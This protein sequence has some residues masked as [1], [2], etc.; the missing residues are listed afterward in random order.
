MT[1]FVHVRNGSVQVGHQYGIFTYKDTL[2]PKCLV[3]EPCLSGV[4][5]IVGTGVTISPHES[6]YFATVDRMLAVEKRPRR[7]RGA[8]KLS[9]LFEILMIASR[10]ALFALKAWENRVRSADR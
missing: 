10:F 3:N 6:M 1:F 8:P 9:A 7:R 4:L 5:Q 2:F